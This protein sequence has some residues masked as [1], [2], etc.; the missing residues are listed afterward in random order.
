MI[1]NLVLMTTTKRWLGR[2]YALKD[3]VIVSLLNGLVTKLPSKCLHSQ[4]CAALNLGQKSFILP[5]I[6]VNVN[7]H[8]CPKG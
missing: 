8:K 2:S 1:V 5:C 3:P 4:I 7:I 6:M